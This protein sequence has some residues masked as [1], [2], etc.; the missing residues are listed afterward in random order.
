MIER[1]LLVSKAQDNTDFELE[2]LLEQIKSLEHLEQQTFLSDYLQTTAMQQ[3]TL[4]LAQ[5]PQLTLQSLQHA[6][7]LIDLDALSAL[8]DD[9]RQQHQ[10]TADALMEL[11]SHYQFDIL[12][13]LLERSLSV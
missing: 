13:Q 7:R 1:L 3:L 2:P 8:I 4:E 11:V 9:M 12:H 5:L 6:T 10:P